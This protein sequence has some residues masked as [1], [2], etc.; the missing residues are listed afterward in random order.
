MLGQSHKTES[1]NV[2]RLAEVIKWNKETLIVSA[3][4]SKECHWRVYVHY[5][6]GKGKI[7]DYEKANTFNCSLGYSFLNTNDCKRLLNVIIV[8]EVEES[9]RQCQKVIDWGE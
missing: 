9:K 3:C 4:E 1:Q 5:L 7:I 2:T 8:T 6:I